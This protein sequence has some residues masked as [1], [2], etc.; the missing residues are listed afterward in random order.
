MLV[1]VV[2][3]VDVQIGR[4]NV[5]VQNA[6]QLERVLYRRI[7][8]QRIAQPQAIVKNSGNQRPLVRIRRF[9]LDQRSEAHN[10]FGRQSLREL[11]RVRRRR[12]IPKP[13]GNSAPS[14]SPP[15]RM[16]YAA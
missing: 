14:S 11:L 6:V 7:A 1:R 10:L 2:R 16:S 8:L 4:P 15:A 3:R 12:V 13:R 5:L 9:P